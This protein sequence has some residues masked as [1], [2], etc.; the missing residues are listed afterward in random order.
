MKIQFFTSNLFSA[1]L[2]DNWS[3]LRQQGSETSVVSSL[4]VSHILLTQVDEQMSF[5]TFFIDWKKYCV[6]KIYIKYK[7]IIYIT[8]M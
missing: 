5:T 2:E 8:I 6:Y 7:N 4:K 1:F 3:N